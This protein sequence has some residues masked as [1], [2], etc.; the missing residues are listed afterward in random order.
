[1]FESR[2]PAACCV[3]AALPLFGLSQNGSRGRSI[4]LSHQQCNTVHD[5]GVSISPRKSASARQALG[6]PHDSEAIER[7]RRDPNLRRQL[8]GFGDQSRDYSPGKHLQMR[9]SRYIQIAEVRWASALD[10]QWRRSSLIPLHLQRRPPCCSG[11]GRLKFSSSALPLGTRC[12]QAPT[13]TWQS[14]GCRR[15]STSRQSARLRTSS[16]DQLTSWI[17][18]IPHRLFGIFLAAGSWFV[19]RDLAAEIRVGLEEFAI[20]RQQFQPLIS[21][22]SDAT[23][24]VI[25]TSAASA[26]L[27]S[28]YT[29]IEKILKLI[30]REWD[31]QLPSSIHG[32]RICGFKCRKRGPS[33]QQCFQ[34]A[35]WKFSASFWRSGTFFEELLSPSC[36]GI[37]YIR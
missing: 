14:V 37:S 28:F 36:G 1:M 30:A 13:S 35:W 18:T 4:W 16:A 10:C 33:V 32:I 3:R 19:S 23:V 22:S 2:T 34:P 27:H 17:W 6:V 24:G 5:P 26:M 9:D 7:P 25:E 12:D 29:E 8:G 15:P 20:V 11:W 21:L 31:S